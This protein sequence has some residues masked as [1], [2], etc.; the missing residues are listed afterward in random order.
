M[1]MQ[2]RQVLKPKYAC[3]FIVMC[4]YECVCVCACVCVCVCVHQA[5]VRCDAPEVLAS[6]MLRANEA[7]LLISYHSVHA[8][9][10][11]WATEQEL[12]KVSA[13]VRRRWAQRPAP[14]TL[15]PPALQALVSAIHLRVCVCVFYTSGGPGS[16]CDA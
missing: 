13:A 10:T 8:A 16:G 15:F 2:S 9:L 12:H 5:C 6:A 14:C 4:V 3:L 1:R 11:H 7:G